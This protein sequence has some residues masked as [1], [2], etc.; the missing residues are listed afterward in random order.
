MNLKRTTMLLMSFTLI[1]SAVG[2]NR[3]QANP[4]TDV[5]NAQENAS[6]DKNYIEKYSRFYGDNV[7][8]LKRYQ[9]Y[10]D[11]NATNEYYAT[12]EYPGNEAYL[13]EVKAGYRDTKEKMQ[14]FVDYLKN[15]LNTDDES[16]KQMK[17]ELVTEG[18]QIISNIDV[19][20]KELEELP[21]DSINKSQE[22]FIKLVNE[23]KTITNDARTKFSD[24]LKNMNTK[25]GIG[26]N[27]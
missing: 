22:E 12:N 26:M 20:L 8:D 1:F 6:L 18:E 4:T 11:V 5:P 10:G 24:I 9:M 21:K 3:Q 15:D 16:L 7:S 25:L 14:S 17:N 19:R 13:N 23:S 2:C 27:K